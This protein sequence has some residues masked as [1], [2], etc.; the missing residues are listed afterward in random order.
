MRTSTLNA[1]G[2]APASG[3]GLSRRSPRRPSPGMGSGGRRSRSGSARRHR[4]SPPQ[5]HVSMS[6]RFPRPPG[7]PVA[8][9]HCQVDGAGAP[10]D[11]A[12]QH[13]LVDATPS[14]CKVTGSQWRSSAVVCG[15]TTGSHCACA[16][17]RRCGRL[18]RERPPVVPH[19]FGQ[20]FANGLR[21][22]PAHPGTSGIWTRCLSRSPVRPTTCGGLLT[23]TAI[24][25]DILVTSRRDAKAATR[26]VG[27]PTA[28]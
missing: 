11:A 3:R 25:L 24:S 18:S 4:V 22:W 26:H 19:K 23:N 6:S 15:C 27:L 1:T 10:R 20:S 12:G 7:T 28:A 17:C 21:R 16:T 14:S 5:W 13:D 2:A 9:G 8:L